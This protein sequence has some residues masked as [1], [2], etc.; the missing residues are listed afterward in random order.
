VALGEALNLAVLAEGVETS[1]Q[2]A[3]ISGEGCIAYQ[4]YF[5]SKP[6]SED[7]LRTLL[8]N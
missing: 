7:I 8:F 5:F 1:E 2:Y 6:L 4:G 3:F